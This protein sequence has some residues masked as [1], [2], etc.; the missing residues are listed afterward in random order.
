M[1]VAALLPMTEGSMVSFSSSFLPFMRAVTTP[2][3]EDASTTVSE[4]L[5]SIC[6]CICWAWPIMSFILARSERFMRYSQ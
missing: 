1:S 5:C 3:P 2:P 4:S 6:S